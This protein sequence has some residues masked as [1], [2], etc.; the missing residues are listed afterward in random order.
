MSGV[1]SV[2]EAPTIVFEGWMTKRAVVSGRNWKRRYFVL[3]SDGTLSYKN[4]NTVD[5]VKKSILL[6]SKSKAMV[7]KELSSEGGIYIE[8]P[9]HDSLYLKAE[10]MKEAKQW[11]QVIND[12]IK[13]IGLSDA[14]K[15]NNTLEVFAK[16]NKTV[17]HFLLVYSISHVCCS[18]P[19]DAMMAGSTRK[20]GS[21]GAAPSTR[22]LGSA[23]RIGAK[24]KRTPPPPEG[25]WLMRVGDMKTA[26]DV[27]VDANTW[28]YY[29]DK[30]SFDKGG[31]VLGKAELSNLI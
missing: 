28:M 23:T 25:G 29:V 22:Q 24:E 9:T 16:A 11:I 20:L 10:S 6:T 7:L 8:G 18:K 5:T 3:L 21:L 14:N 26:K 15:R 30:E 27:F 13:Q 19:A 31:K 12:L 17:R 1:L 2:G 4:S